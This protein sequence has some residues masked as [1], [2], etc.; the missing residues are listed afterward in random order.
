MQPQPPLP[1]SHRTTERK[2]MHFYRHNDT[3]VLAT[4][5]A[6]PGFENVLYA[7]WCGENSNSLEEAILSADNLKAMTSV[8][9]PDVPDE[10][11]NAFSNASGL[12]AK[13]EPEPE[14]E[15]EFWPEPW[16]ESESWSEP[17]PEPESEVWSVTLTI[18]DLAVIFAIWFAWNVLKCSMGWF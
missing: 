11:Y 17:E 5:E 1:S 16:P 2:A 8:E 13:R 18:K 10:W 7:V 12:F 4:G 9:L 3:Y 14:P 6:P 15:P